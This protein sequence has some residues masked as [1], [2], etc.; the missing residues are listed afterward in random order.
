MCNRMD[1]VVECNRKERGGCNDQ[2][3]GACA[4]RFHICRA[5]GMCGICGCYGPDSLCITE[6]PW[7][8][9]EP[10]KFCGEWFCDED[11]CPGCKKQLHSNYPSVICWECEKLQNEFFRVSSF[12]PN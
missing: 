1:Y 10:C 8:E 2:S 12:Y 5:N 4:Y 7:A 9:D 11:R 6:C 3:C